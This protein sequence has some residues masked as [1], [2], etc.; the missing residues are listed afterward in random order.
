MRGY[1]IFSQPRKGAEVQTRKE[2]KI[3][4][5]PFFS[6]KNRFKLCSKPIF[7]SLRLSVFAPLR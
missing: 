1:S 4:T 6:I 7:I 2:G 3:K 5:K